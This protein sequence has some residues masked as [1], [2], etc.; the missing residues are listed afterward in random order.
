MQAKTSW[1]NGCCHCRPVL[2]GTVPLGKKEKKLLVT[3][4]LMFVKIFKAISLV[5]LG[6]V[7][8]GV[9]FW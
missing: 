4:K 6:F 9:C 5:N 3:E 7:F 8:V 1:R 2:A